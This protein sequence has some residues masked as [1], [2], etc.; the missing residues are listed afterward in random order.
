MGHGGDV[1]KELT[2]DHAEVAGL[3]DR[4]RSSRPGSRERKELVDEVTERLVRHA[5]AEEQYLYPAVREH[6]VD[7]EALAEKELR[8]HSRIAETLNA[9]AG[10]DSGDPGFS[11]LLVVLVTG[12]TAHVRDEEERLFP[13]LSAACP[14]EVLRD[15]GDKVRRAE[16][17]APTRPHP[18]APDR[19]PAIGAVSPWLGLVDKIRDKIRDFVTRRAKPR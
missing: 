15:L 7:G 10:V 17:I 4:I 8:D 16:R 12:V 11:E 9:L 1:I 2:A 14:R 6:V 13:R 18:A 5:V 3:F 19:P